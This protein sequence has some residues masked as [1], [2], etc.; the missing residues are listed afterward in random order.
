MASES[1]LV[2]QVQ[3][4]TTYFIRKVCFPALPVKPYQNIHL[5]IASAV[6]YKCKDDASHL[7]FI[8]LRGQ[9]FPKIK[10]YN[11]QKEL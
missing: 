4:L 9:S 2:F 6:G 7:Y 8:C 3:S 11:S 5:L 1:V 10:I